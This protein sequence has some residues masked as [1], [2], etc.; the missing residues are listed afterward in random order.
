M[1]ELA[2][3]LAVTNDLV[4]GT[5]PEYGKFRGVVTQLNP[6][7]IHRYAPSVVR[8]TIAHVAVLGFC[9]TIAVVRESLTVRQR[10]AVPTTPAE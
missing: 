5:H 2:G 8:I 3:E 1:R 6:F 4:D 9:N 7:T 10:D